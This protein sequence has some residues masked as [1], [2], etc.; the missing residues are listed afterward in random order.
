MLTE[1]LIQFLSDVDSY[2]DSTQKVSVVQTHIS[3]VALLD[4]V[5]YK[6]K[7][8]VNFG[9]LDFTSLERR[10]F[11]LEEEIRLNQRLTKDV[12]WQI[13][14]LYQL[15]HGKLTFDPP[16]AHPEKYL[17]EYGLKMRRLSH[18]NFLDELIKKP[19]FDW[20]KLGLVANKLARFYNRVPVQ[21]E[22]SQW[23]T[24]ENIRLSIEE[25]F[26]QI[27]PFIKNTIQPL[28]FR[29]IRAFQ[30]YFL[31]NNAALFQQR[32]DDGKILECHGDL[33]AEHVHVED[34]EVNVYDCIEFNERFR[35]IDILNDV[36]FLSMDLDFRHKYNLSNFFVDEITKQVE[37]GEFMD[38]LDFYKSYRAFVK[39][40]VESFTSASLEVPAKIRHKCSEKARKYFKLSLKYALIGS[41]ATL[42]VVY[43]GVATGKTT[44]A[45]K[46]AKHMG[47]QHFNSDFIR[48][49]MAGI[50]TYERTKEED[51][52]RVYSKEMT[53]QVYTA[54]FERGIECAFQEGTAILDA[55]FRDVSKLE[56]LLDRV[57]EVQPL[58]V[59]FIE[60]VAPDEVI[61]ERLLAREDEGS[62]SDARIEHFEM[63]KQTHH[64]IA[65][66][67]PNHLTLN[68]ASNLQTTMVHLFVQMFEARLL[69]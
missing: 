11:Y 45:Q 52:H 24:R 51:L 32:I 50:P 3:V 39:G 16:P 28:E 27:K 40:K 60:A 23:G 61:K 33:K 4:E 26:E 7:K 37:E 53:E 2:G 8:P 41:Q 46:I 67:L 47:I 14:P 22:V 36:A 62:V 65:E 13:V 68:T 56:Q 54:L 31:E 29:V 69:D 38:L 9:F 19:T 15:P 48:K 34:G 17:V 44:L 5:V 18:I 49:Q 25:N 42:V 43:G 21:D 64:Q 66:L 1:D 10:K 57:R 20:Q 55:T 63:L 12:Y 58:R 59:V 35:C 6:F 30:F